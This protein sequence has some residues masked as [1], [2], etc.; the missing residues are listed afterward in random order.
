LED[1]ELGH[2]CLVGMLKLFIF[3]NRLL[4]AKNVFDYRYSS[5]SLL[6]TCGWE[7]ARN[8]DP[9]QMS[10]WRRLATLNDRISRNS[11]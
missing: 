10:L 3:Q 11:L 8:R 9:R 7:A 5:M 6:Q 2:A 4:V 1:L